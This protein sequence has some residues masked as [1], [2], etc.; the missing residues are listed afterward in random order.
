LYHG[1]PQGVRQDPK[2]AEAY[3]GQA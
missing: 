3:L 1:P 2:V